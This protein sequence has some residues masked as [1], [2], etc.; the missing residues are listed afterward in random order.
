[1]F[2]NNLV[3]QEKVAIEIFNKPNKRQKIVL[4]IFFVYVIALVVVLCISADHIQNLTTR[5]IIALIGGSPLFIV[6]AIGAIR[7]FMPDMELAASQIR[8]KYFYLD[9]FGYEYDGFYRNKKQKT[10]EVYFTHAE[11]PPIC[12]VLFFKKRFHTPYLCFGNQ[13]V[14]ML[15]LA[16]VLFPEK[17]ETESEE[18]SAEDCI[19]AVISQMNENWESVVA[20]CRAVYCEEDSGRPLLTGNDFCR[21]YE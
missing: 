16:E 20:A 18:P 21:Y 1:M 12:F 15:T 2:E 17:F 8:G 14:S 4:G 6:F 19:K 3:N 9:D 13:F 7:L 5:R 10:L 11:L